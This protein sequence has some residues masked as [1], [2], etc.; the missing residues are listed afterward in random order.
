VDRPRT[1]K[2]YIANDSCIC[3]YFKTYSNGWVNRSKEASW[4]EGKF[5]VREE[6]IE[7]Q[8]K[9]LDISIEGIAIR[10]LKAFCK[11]G[12]W[13]GTALCM[14]HNNIIFDAVKLFDEM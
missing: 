2:R 8:K 11:M 5:S 6:I 7:T 3:E 13:E 10:L 9:Y 12:S 1:A 14:V 4:T